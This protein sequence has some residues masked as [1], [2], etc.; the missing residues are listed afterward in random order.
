MLHDVRRQRIRDV[1]ARRLAHVC[2]AAEHTWHRHNVSALLR[3]AD[4]AGVLDVHLVGTRAFE[5]SSGPSRGT[6][7]WLNLHHHETAADAVTAIAAAG[8]DLWVAD[9]AEEPVGPEG[10]PLQRPVC[11][12]FG[13]ELLGV[14]PEAR[15]AAAGVV[16]L[17]MRGMGQSL[18]LAACAT[19]ILHVVTGRAL[20][21]HGDRALLPPDAR[22][23][24]TESWL[25]REPARPRPS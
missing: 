20:A 10:I 15:A 1:A 13:A 5:P 6:W 9:F 24:L 12:W 3:S 2:V 21:E 14:S 25:E 8:Y 22:D 4:A 7:R 16:T 23:A 11:L 18:N 19:A 17:P